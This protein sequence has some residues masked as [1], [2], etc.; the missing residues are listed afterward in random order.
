MKGAKRWVRYF[1]KHLFH[2]LA[3][4]QLQLA[5]LDDFDVTVNIGAFTEK[6]QH[7]QRDR[8]FSKLQV[9]NSSP[10]EF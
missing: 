4:N 1:L 5:F 7:G 2:L 10:V 3:M 6:Q 9:N 8:N